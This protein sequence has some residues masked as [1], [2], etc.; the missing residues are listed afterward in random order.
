MHPCS[1]EFIGNQG[2][3]VI[4]HYNFWTHSVN[5]TECMALIGRIENSDVGNLAQYVF[6][7]FAT[8]YFLNSFWPKVA[9][10]IN[11]QDRFSGIDLLSIVDTDGEAKLRFSGS[12]PAKEICHHARSNA[13]TKYT[14]QR[15]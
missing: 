13:T 9:G 12:A 3:Y 14:V 2:R 8:S 4:Y 10:C 15:P 7:S 11:K 1:A 5:S 6:F